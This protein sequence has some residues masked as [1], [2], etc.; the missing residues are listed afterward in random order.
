MQPYDPLLTI[1][2]QEAR[3]KPCHVFH[4]FH[5]IR[6]MGKQFN[7]AAF[8]HFT[9]LETRHVERIMEALEAHDVMPAK[10]TTSDA[11]GTRLPV[12]WA[13]PQD[14]IDWAVQ[15][16]GWEP[17]S[18]AEEAAGFAD[19]WQSKTGQAA[20]KLDWRKTWQNWV[21]NSRRPNGTYRPATDTQSP[22]KWIAFCEE[23][24]TWAKDNDYR[25]GIK[26]W[27]E[28]LELARVKALGNVLPFGRVG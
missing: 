7:P 3:V 11:R 2:A 4:C 10:R 24:L 20:T 12:D 8:A 18:A 6:A 15:L 26:E 28:K 1:M 17:S 23:R 9:G 19:Y 25:A 22:E 27:S 13:M 21:R 5:A 16:K 14:W